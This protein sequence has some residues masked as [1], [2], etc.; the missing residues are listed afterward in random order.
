MKRR[1]PIIALALAIV[2]AAFAVFSPR[3]A[4]AAKHQD[5]LTVVELFTSQGCGLCRP[6]DALLGELTKRADLLPL[7]FHVNYWDYI[8]WKDTFASAAN[9]TR[10]RAYARRFG[11]R[12]VYTPQMVIQGTA[13]AA[14]SNRASVLADIEKH[15][16]L[17][18]VPI[19]IQRGP[20]GRSIIVTIAAD[21]QGKKQNADVW[22]VMFDRNRKTAVS[23]GENRGKTL[24]DFNVVR[25]LKKV[26][27]WDGGK[28]KF[29]V[30]SPGDVVLSGDCAILLQ[31]AGPGRILGAAKLA[32]D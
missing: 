24:S 16:S 20:G 31:S 2:S 17:S 6:A 29:T 15:K 7:S 14:G 27:E 8:G 32:L 11:Q 13:Q 28:M 21:P 18:P 30:N 22:L 23:R 19:K 1:L 4:A 12:Y 26:A 25:S 10:Q 3:P 5:L 9:T